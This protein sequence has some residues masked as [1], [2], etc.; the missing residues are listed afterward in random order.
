MYII[1]YCTQVYLLETE[2]HHTA[3]VDLKLLIPLP[4]PSK[5]W[6]CKCVPQ[7]LVP[8]SI[9]LPLSEYSTLKCL[10]GSLETR[11]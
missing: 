5:C 9:T 3:N 4:Q 7:G 11:S 2:T 1:R 8:T 10:W 6:G